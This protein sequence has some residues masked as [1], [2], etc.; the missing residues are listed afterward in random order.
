MLTKFITDHKAWLLSHLIWI[1]GVAIALVGIHAW[2]GEH[3]AR[4]ASDA[5]IKISEAT[6]ASL[7]AQI[8]ATNAAAAQK[9]QVITKIVHDVATPPE[10]I[11]AVPQLT[12]VPLNARLIPNNP[13]QISVDYLPLIDLLGQAKVDKTNLD[14]C[15]VDLQNETAIVTAKQTEIVALKKKPSFWKRVGGVAKAVGVGI[16]IGMLLQAHGL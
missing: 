10:A 8:V 7:Q 5:Q 16:G 11:A 1:V 13:V 4:I 3:D 2:I 15:T 14:A 6:V 12:D 9:V